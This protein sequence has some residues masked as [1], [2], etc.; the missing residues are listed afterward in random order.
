MALIT[1]TECKGNVSE[2]A[3]TCPHCGA[4]V[5]PVSTISRRSLKRLPTFGYVAKPQE[6]P[7]EV[8]KWNEAAKE[9][10]GLEGEALEKQKKLVEEYG[11]NP[12]VRKYLEDLI[13]PYT[14]QEKDD[15]KN[16]TQ[17][18]SKED[19]KD[20]KNSIDSKAKSKNKSDNIW[21]IA[22]LSI[23]GIAIILIIFYSKHNTNSKEVA[24]PI[25]V[26]SPE[27]VEAQRINDSISEADYKK[28]QV[29]FV[30]NMES[31]V[32]LTSSDDISSFLNQISRAIEIIKDQTDESTQKKLKKSLVAY[33]IKM[34]P[35]AR[36]LY[37][38]K[39]KD[40][41]WRHDIDVTANGKTINLTG[42]LFAA[43]A[44]IEDTYNGLKNALWNL[45]FKQVNFRWYKGASEYTYYTTDAPG[46][47]ELVDPR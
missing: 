29:E 37:I 34:F 10:E 47:D 18:S 28:S 43:N 6:I 11:N 32:R 7:E 23:L 2:F 35:K 31:N 14:K 12:V 3:K 9:M 39:A 30:L 15:S 42:G 16:M 22:A 40:E 25:E 21:L 17:S 4:P 38:Q 33:Q 26:V 44:N 41:L 36:K 24:N 19:N 8:K 27:E 46:D 45:R 13:A 5:T 20:K 1:C